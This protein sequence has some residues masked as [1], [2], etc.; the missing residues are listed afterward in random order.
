MN[1][2]NNGIVTPRQWHGVTRLLH[3]LMAVGIIGQL[4]FP[5]YGCT[6]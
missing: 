5:V 4:T 6:R 1:D 3:G 2:S